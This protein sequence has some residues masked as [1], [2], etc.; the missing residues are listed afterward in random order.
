MWGAVVRNCREW[1][2]LVS[3]FFPRELLPPAMA[4]VQARPAESQKQFYYSGNA[5]V[6]HAMSCHLL[7]VNVES[8][9]QHRT[10]VRWAEWSQL[11]VGLR[12]LHPCGHGF[13]TDLTLAPSLVG[14]PAQQP[15]TA[16]R[17]RCT[18]AQAFAI[19]LKGRMRAGRTRADPNDPTRYRFDAA[20]AL[21]HVRGIF[22]FWCLARR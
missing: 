9:M 12:P 11:S 8:C 22:L 13:L 20:S 7:A 19:V 15:G 1:I 14:L 3:V 10:E 2:R 18:C 5:C 17:Q 21:L 4:Y 6:K 16:R